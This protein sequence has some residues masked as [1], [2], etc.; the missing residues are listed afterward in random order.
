M[1]AI[2]LPRLGRKPKAA[3]EPLPPPLVKPTQ[4]PLT[5]L[6]QTLTLVVAGA[7]L[8]HIGTLVVV[9]LYY[10]LFGADGAFFW[11]YHAPL[12]DWWHH[13][14][15]DDHTR[16]MLRN[17]YE[18]VLGGTLGQLI[19]FNRYKIKPKKMQKR[20]LLDRV[21]IKLHIPNIKD[22]RN[23]AWYDLVLFLPLVMLYAA[24]GFWLGMKIA[25]FVKALVYLPAQL[26]VGVVGTAWYDQMLNFWERGADEKIVGL[27]ASFFLARRIIRGF[28]DNVQGY[29]AARRVNC[30]L[31]VRPW[32]TPNFKARVNG[33]TE[34]TAARRFDA[35]GNA[36]VYGLSALIVAA[37]VLAGLG[38][39]ILTWIA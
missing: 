10:F 20:S 30:G 6:R 25:E 9:A 4:S 3:R 13:L 1:S 27:F 2:A 5:W 31:G 29:F 26:S 18:G 37:L 33:M 16:H 11:G 22:D 17:V 23:L 39:Y 21:E 38:W 14:V 19:V 12:N 8:V 32:H 15:P 24:P 34:A 35:T 7:L 28:A 36:V